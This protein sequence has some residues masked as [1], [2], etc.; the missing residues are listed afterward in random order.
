MPHDSEDD[1]PNY[2]KDYMSCGEWF[3]F[4][5]RRAL[6]VEEGEGQG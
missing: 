3:G 5:Q 6:P 1:A 4:G 2:G